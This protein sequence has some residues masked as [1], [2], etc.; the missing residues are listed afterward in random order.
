MSAVEGYAVVERTLG[1]EEPRGAA[2]QHRH[3]QGY[4]YWPLGGLPAR[5]GV[6]GPARSNTC[7]SGPKRQAGQG[8]RP[9]P[10]PLGPCE[11]EG[12]SIKFIFLKERREQPFGQIMDHTGEPFAP[13]A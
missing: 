8:N 3:R 5:D 1:G 4:D 9:A 12:S 2:E 10:V 11:F 6:L 13:R 7:I